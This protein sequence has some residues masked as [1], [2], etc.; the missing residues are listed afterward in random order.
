[1]TAAQEALVPLPDPTAGPVERAAATMLAGMLE[2]GEIT[3]EADG[4]LIA[5]V[6]ALASRLDSPRER[7]YGLAQVSREL[8][9]VYV[10]LD[11]R[12]AAAGP[13]T[14]DPLMALLEDD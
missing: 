3:A 4:L 2:R 14:V 11:G 7:A 8:R 1:M 5:H 12:R 10:Y 9:E 13:A 6:T